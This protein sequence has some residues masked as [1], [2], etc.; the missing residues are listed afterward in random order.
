MALQ[1]GKG[2]EQLGISLK[3]RK[4]QVGKKREK[5]SPLSLYSYGEE[6]KN[7]NLLHYQ[8]K[9]NR[10][11]E[12]SLPP[13]LPLLE[14]KKPASLYKKGGVR[15]LR[16]RCKKK[17]GQAKEERS[18]ICPT[19]K[20]KHSSTLGNHCGKGKTLPV[21]LC[22]EKKGCRQKKTKKEERNAR[23]RLPAASAAEKRKKKKTAST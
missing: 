5:R 2:A 13:S 4:R 20:K 21:A 12:K 16:P 17:K 9:G 18:I 3:K 19:Q 7:L 14:E 6:Q 11:W 1:K 8:R 10:Q 23:P 15:L 22:L